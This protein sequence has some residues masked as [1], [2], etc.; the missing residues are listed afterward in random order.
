MYE[1]Q[2]VNAR[3]CTFDSRVGSLETRGQPAGDRLTQFID[4]STLEPQLDLQHK[5]PEISDS[6]FRLKL[7]RQTESRQI[8]RYRAT[9]SL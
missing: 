1:F 7:V 9:C 5:I 8:R 6:S 2:F 4:P 3:T